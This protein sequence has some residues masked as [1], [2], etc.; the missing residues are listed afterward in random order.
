MSIRK[1]KTAE[2][3]TVEEKIQNLPNFKSKERVL[4]FIGD[5]YHRTKVQMELESYHP[6][7]GEDSVPTLQLDDDYFR[8]R[9]GLVH[10]IDTRLADCSEDTKLI[11][12]NDF[13]DRKG[14]G[15]WKKFFTKSAYSYRKKN[16][17]EE[18]IHHL[19]L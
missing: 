11:I 2:K 18:F 14:A 5:T 1:T 13:L 15:W 3:H 19:D 8:N 9:D 7:S 10:L 17:V 12:R 16:A 4:E 6:I